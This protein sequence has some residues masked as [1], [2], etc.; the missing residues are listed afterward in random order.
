[1]FSYF[2]MRKVNFHCNSKVEDQLTLN[3]SDKNSNEGEAPE[4][5]ESSSNR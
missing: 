3:S 5:H 4:N 1:M 2:G